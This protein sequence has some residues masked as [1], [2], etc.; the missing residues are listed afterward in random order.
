VE[1]GGTALSWRTLARW[2]APFVITIGALWW[3]F[4]DVG[5][6]DAAAVITVDTL[7]VLTPALFAFAAVSLWVEAEC[8]VRLLPR[9]GDVEFGRGT[10]ARIKA[11]S[12]P[13]GLIHYAIGAGGLGILLA[14][15]TG[16]TIAHATG[17]VAL[18][19]LFDIGVQLLMMVVGV[20]ALGTDAPE[21]R[22][23][24]AI[25]AVAAMFFGFFALRTSI[26]LGPLDRIRELSIL[27]ASRTTPIPL[28]VQLGFLRF[29]FALCFLGLI[30]ASCYAF[31]IAVPPLVLLA[32][33][34]ILIVVAMVPSV[35]GLGTGQVAFIEV[36][37]RY[38]A[39][40]T[41]L[42][43]SLALSTGLIIIRASMGLLFARE[44]TR[45]ALVAT[46]ASRSADT[47]DSEGAGA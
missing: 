33:V 26:S 43:C 16:R 39:E 7:M 31:G 45:E 8:L 22:A 12:Y 27:D 41:L 6:A 35:A 21:V 23:G 38:A 5:L 46:T 1:P 20:T 18:I 13:L 4:D 42:A 25:A 47:N 17:V 37:Q 14:R 36:F 24:I 44:F 19:A 34:P 28:L 29:L 30:G 3:V 32:S 40:E 15:R 2:V 11:A 10:A 9:T